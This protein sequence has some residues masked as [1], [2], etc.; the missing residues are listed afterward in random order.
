LAADGVG[1]VKTLPAE[2]VPV[3]PPLRPDAGR[4]A[5]RLPE[6]LNDPLKNMSLTAGKF[7]EAALSGEAA[8]RTLKDVAGTA[9]VQ[10]LLVNAS[11][12]KRYL[13]VVGTIAGA[14]AAFDFTV[15]FVGIKKAS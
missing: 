11:D 14:S 2:H 10:S 4:G 5:D 6:R 12:L 7:R 3:Q 13:R 15:G 1:V 9:G 8:F